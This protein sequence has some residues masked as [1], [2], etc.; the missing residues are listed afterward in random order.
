MIR[1]IFALALSLASFR[2]IV[3][4]STAYVV[5]GGLTVGIQKW[6]NSF[7][8][9]PLFKL[10]GSLS[11]ES[12]DNENDRS[13]LFMQIGYHTKG[14]ATRFQVFNQQ[15]GGI[16][17]YSEEF[18]FNNISLI[19][20]AK[21]KFPLGASSRYFYYGGIRGDYTLSTNI[22]NLA[23]DNPYLI[24]YY[25]QI[26]SMNRWMLGLSVGG[27]IE[28]K[29]AE[30]IGGQLTVSVHPDVTNQ[31]N[32]PPIPNVIN[33]L[34][35]GQTTTIPARKIRNTTLELTVGLRLLRKVEYVE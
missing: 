23:T 34:S 14:S 16:R 7:E 12:V 28:F 26:G 30:L 17:T 11:I 22:D 4:Q 33:P 10:H 3:A 13:A 15:G 9:E 1:F 24:G 29:F 18:R 19:L 35:P 31:Y 2:Q 6:D 32:Q 27:G 21:Q 20:G 8:R 25:P 5:Q